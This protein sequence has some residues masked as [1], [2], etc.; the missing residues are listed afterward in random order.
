MAK[1][2]VVTEEMIDQALKLLEKRVAEPPLAQ[3]RIYSRRDAFLRLKARAKEAL[4]TGHSL[5]TI[6]D[7]LKGVG[8]GMTL[9][10]ARQYMKPGRKMRRTHGASAPSEQTEPAKRKAELACPIFCAK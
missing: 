3:V 10:T 4:A 6:L 1:N 2:R 9:S 8:I 7:D 5:E